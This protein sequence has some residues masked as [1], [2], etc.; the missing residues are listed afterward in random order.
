MEVL[1]LSKSNDA[2][3]H[4]FVLH[5]PQA[6]FFHLPGW[7]TILE[8]TFGLK[9]H[10]L[11][12]QQGGQVQGVLPLISIKSKLGGNY[13]T[14]VPG[15]LCAENPD[16]A[17]ALIE[18]AKTLTKATKA[19]YLILR[20]S[21]DNW[22]DMGLI[23][24]AEHC[25]APVTLHS[26]QEDTWM[27]LKSET[28]R[29]VKKASKNGLE[30]K[31]GLEYL[32]DYYPIYL[33]AMRGKGTPT[34][35]LRFFRN[36][37][38]QFPNRFFLTI[39]C[40]NDQVIGGGFVGRMNHTLYCLWSGMLR[41]FYKAY[42]NDLLYW[43]TIKISYK[44]HLDCV[45]LGRSQRDSGSYHFKRK[46]GVKSRTLYQLYYLNGI[47]QPPAVG[48]SMDSNPKY[49]LFVN[50]WRHLP[51]PVTEMIGPHLRKRMPFG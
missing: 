9:T 22:E 4:D 32:D 23:A 20:D 19:K 39:I 36:V 44:Q 41:R 33:E 24:T 3:W 34:Y 6:T 7:Q 47:S 35:G 29:R 26:D 31:A 37:A 38:A 45:D 42:P 16:T 40:H 46:W 18:Q 14:S 43:E 28:R 10:F 12:A 8:Q 27:A 15:G 5:A 30:F 13:L 11:Y 2:P 1:E 17:V 50:T 49:R 48:Q 21:Q 51:L 25:S